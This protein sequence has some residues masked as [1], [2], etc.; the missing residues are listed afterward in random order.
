MATRCKFQCQSVRKY[1]HYNPDPPYVYEAEFSAVTSGSD[2]NKSF[3]ASTPSGKLNVS[4]YRDDVFQPGKSYYI[5][6]SE[7]E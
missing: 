3:F 5:D 7:A 2:E 4:T 6:I 1:K